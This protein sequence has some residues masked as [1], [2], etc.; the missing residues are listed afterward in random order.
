MVSTWVLAAL[1]PARPA[2]LLFR[3]RARPADRACRDHP[4]RA[5]VS[6]RVLAALAP[7]RPAWL[8][9]RSRARPADRAC[10][11]HPPRAVVST[12]VLA[13]LAP[14]RPAGRPAAGRGPRDTLPDARQ[15]ANSAARVHNSVVSATPR[16]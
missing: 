1:A 2:W 11:D 3:S 9:F 16:Q 14:A 6:T 15:T 13:A 4:P 10:R 8:L 7:A 5:V 12:W